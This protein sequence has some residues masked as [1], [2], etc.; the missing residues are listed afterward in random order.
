MDKQECQKS[1]LPGRA[2]QARQA[3]FWT[4]LFFGVLF[5]AIAAL[6]YHKTGRT[7]LA[8]IFGVVGLIELVNVLM[9]PFKGG[10]K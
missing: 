5:V 2:K 8:L 7:V 9:N 1:S 10:K 3:W 6:V 4:H